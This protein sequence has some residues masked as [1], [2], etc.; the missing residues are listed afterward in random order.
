[1]AQPL[2]EVLTLHLIFDPHKMFS[3]SPLVLLKQRLR[4]VEG[5]AQC[6]TAS[7]V[8]SAKQEQTLQVSISRIQSSQHPVS[9]QKY[10]FADKETDT[11]IPTKLR[12]HRRKTS[13]ISPFCWQ[14]LSTLLHF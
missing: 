9:Q 2:S 12:S 4:E 14:N 5:F 8:L 10:K 3:P 13:L 7:H 1:M 6:H 11:D